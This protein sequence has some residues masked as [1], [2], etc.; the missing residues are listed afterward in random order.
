MATYVML[1]SFTE[2]GVQSI[3]E[4]PSRSAA[5][6]KEVQSAGGTV[7]EIYWTLGKYDGI[8]I[9][10]APND[11]TATALILTL[12]GRGNT[13]TQTLRAFDEKEFSALLKK[14]K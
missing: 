5:F 7:R 13:K 4:S 12:E 8:A 3:K 14:V 1:L 6:R 11:E 2:K 9:F 10:D